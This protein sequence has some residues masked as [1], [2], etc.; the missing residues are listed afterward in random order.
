MKNLIKDLVK[1]T[2]DLKGFTLLELLIIIVVIALVAMLLFGYLGNP[3][4]STS[5]QSAA[6]QIADN[7]RTLDESWN[8]YYA[9][10][11]AE[12]DSI[13]TLVSTGV[14][15]A[16]PIPPS[17]AKKSGYSGTY[18]YTSDTTTYNISGTAAVDTVIKLVGITD[19]VCKKINHLYAG[20]EENSSIPTAIT[21]GKN[22]QCYSDGNNNVVLALVI[23]K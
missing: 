6:I 4:S 15:K 7:M 17:S 23:S 10:K 1:I 14:L 13:D 19:D 16:K 18:D 5:V 21:N 2:S 3:L 9:E 8:R 12:P 11:T 20:A 22:I